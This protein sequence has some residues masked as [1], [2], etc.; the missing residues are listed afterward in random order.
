MNQIH[1]GG[2]AGATEAY[3]QADPV[4]RPGGKVKSTSAQKCRKKRNKLTTG[5]S[6]RPRKEA[7]K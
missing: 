6:S 7:D 5:R 2:N 4:K 1:G 3:L